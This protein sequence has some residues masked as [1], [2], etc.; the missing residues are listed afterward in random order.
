MHALIIGATGATG[1]DLLDLLLE[2]ESFH[3]VDVFVRR[4]I[5]IQHEKLK[6]HVIDFDQSEQWKHSVKGDVLF[7]CLGTTLKA[8]GSKEAQWKIDYDYQYQ[9][10]KIARENHVSHYVLVSSGGSSPNSPLFYPRMKGQLEE[11]VK[12]LGF[13]G[14]TIFKPTVL[15]RKNSDR[16]MEVAGLKAV[17]FFNRFGL[18]RSQEPMPT[19][20]LAQAMVHS[21]KQP[22]NG[23]FMLE[24][25]AIRECAGKFE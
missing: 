16:T 3:Q 5:P 2:D 21:V 7:S 20:I 14:V 24:G 25:E 9:F 13:P 8:A 19:E 11:S 23:I 4:D 22:R 18:L 1:R 12:D 6:V 17:Q 10:A 15:V